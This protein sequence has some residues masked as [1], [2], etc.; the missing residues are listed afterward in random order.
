MYW[1]VLLFFGT[2]VAI[3]IGTQVLSPKYEMRSPSFDHSGITGEWGPAQ[4]SGCHAT[5]HTAWDD[6]QHSSITF[7][8]THYFPS[9]YYGMSGSQFNGSCYACF[10]TNPTNTSG[11][12]DWWDLGITCAACHEPG[13]IN[14]EAEV[15]GQCHTGGSHA[16]Y[17]DHV[18]SKHNDSLADCI[19]GG[20]P[21]DHCMPCVSGQGTYW[22][23]DDTTGHELWLNNTALTGITC[24]TCHDPHGNDN[25]VQLREDN[26]LDLCGTCHGTSSRH[27]DYE[28]LT[29]TTYKATHFEFNCTVCHGYDAE[30]QDTDHNATNG[31]EPFEFNHTWYMDIPEA[32]NQ[33]D[34]HT[35]KTEDDV[36]AR[37]TDVATKYSEYTALL[38]TVQEKVDE[39]NETDDIDEEKVQEAYDLIDEATGLAQY[40]VSDG[41]SGY[42]NPEFMKAK[43][44]AAMDKLNDA[45]EVGEAAI[46]DAGEDGLIP[47]YGFATLI[48]AMSLLGV[49]VLYLRKRRN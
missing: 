3:G 26:T 41:S 1:M 10:T 5:E 36:T 40:Y 39:A 35:D 31:L 15:C 18:I 47:G 43:L 30:W 22:A 45:K 44:S 48:L 13:V 19:A 17:E 20:H 2:G 11:I 42:H 23:E 32:C 14:H 4:C 46:E 37:Q 33:A 25:V 12:L 27:S 28:Q 16:I 29:D 49:A 34:C 21:A 6:S 38:A 24:A 8:G 9:A 7:N